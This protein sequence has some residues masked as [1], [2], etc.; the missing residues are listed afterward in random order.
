M[1]G[2]NAGFSIG[3]VFGLAVAPLLFMAISALHAHRTRRRAAA[4]TCLTPTALHALRTEDAGLG[5]RPPARLS[6]PAVKGF[7]QHTRVADVDGPAPRVTPRSAPAGSPRRVEGVDRWL[8][9][10]SK[11]LN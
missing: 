8:V 7:G 5:P 9:N 3:V 1:N 10:T 6:T 11:G 4:R 2:F